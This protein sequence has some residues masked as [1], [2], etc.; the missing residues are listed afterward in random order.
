MTSRLKWLLMVLGVVIVG[1]L[2]SIGWRYFYSPLP[3]PSASL[4][5]L[6][7]SETA[8][9]SPSPSA[10]IDDWLTYTNR[11]IGY[12]LR[13]PKDW[14]YEEIV[15][16]NSLY[17]EYKYITLTTKDSKYVLLFGIRKPGDTFSV[18][19]RSGIGADDDIPIPSMATTI[20]DAPVVPHKLNY[21]GKTREYMYSSDDEIKVKC[22][23]EFNAFYSLNKPSDEEEKSAD[24]PTSVLETPNQILQ[25]VR[26]L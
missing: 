12:S 18:I 14:S 8:V 11:D 24:L 19:N 1:F 17:P 9:L 2:I 25:T 26:W 20:L 7:P 21:L 22:N 4:P 3:Q 15:G 10:S 13:Y 5:T 23:C 6:T 16:S